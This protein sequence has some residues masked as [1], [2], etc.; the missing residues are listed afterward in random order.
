MENSSSIDRDRTATDSLKVLAL[1]QSLNNTGYS[2]FK[3]TNNVDYTYLDLDK[4]LITT[5]IIKPKASTPYKDKL[6][7]IETNVSK[8]IEEHKPD[9]VFLE[10]IFTVGKGSW[11]KLIE[12]K[13]II[14]LLL[15]KKGIKTIALSSM[16]K[17]KKSWRAINKLTTADKKYWQGLLQEKNEHIADS[18]GIGLAGLVLLK[19]AD[20]VL[21]LE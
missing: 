18:I 6:I 2:L 10:E 11:R 21:E 19:N 13:V 9:I 14:E 4:V 8:L 16:I 17:H 1:D 3:T 12:V 20:N 7:F 15:Y 5:G